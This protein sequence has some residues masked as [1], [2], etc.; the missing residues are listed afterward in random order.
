M[1]TQWT[2]PWCLPYSTLIAS[3]STTRSGRWRCPCVRSTWLKRLRNGANC[4]ASK[5][6]AVRYVV[7]THP[8]LLP[9]LLTTHSYCY[10]ARVSQWSL[11][12][13]RGFWGSSG[14]IIF[15]MKIYFYWYNVDMQEELLTETDETIPSISVRDDGERGIGTWCDYQRGL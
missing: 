12:C 13:P 7:A 5:A 10:D 3:P 1:R 11:W 8:H 2:R 4:R 6:R 15:I 14:E 9:C